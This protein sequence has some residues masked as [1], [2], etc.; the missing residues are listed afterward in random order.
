MAEILIVEDDLTLS[1]LLQSLIIS[2]GYDVGIVNDGAEAL[3]M[4]SSKHFD[5][6][7]LDLS[8][9]KLSGIQILSE[10]RRQ[11]IKTPV[12][13]V[14]GDISDESEIEC[15]KHGTNLFHKKPIKSRLLL[16]QIQSLLTDTHNKNLVVDEHNIHIDD[17]RKSVKIYGVRIILSKREYEILRLLV[18]KYPKVLSKSYIISSLYQ[19]C[20]EI[21]ESAIDTTISRLRSKIKIALEINNVP[22]SHTNVIKTVR[23]FGYT[24]HSSN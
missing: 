8:L 17:R 1:K 18:S 4:I 5:L 2:K 6:V 24:L 21:Q 9:P 3:E 11:H 13:I 14:T 10:I 20:E 12:I 7:L 22:S 16:Y 23:S 19:E 15:Y